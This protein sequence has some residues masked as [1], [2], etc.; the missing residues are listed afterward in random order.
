MEWCGFLDA[1]WTDGGGGGGGGTL[2]LLHS[3][4]VSVWCQVA[5]LSSLAHLDPRVEFPFE[6]MY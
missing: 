3:S 5:F 4:T 6:N 1:W 2:Y